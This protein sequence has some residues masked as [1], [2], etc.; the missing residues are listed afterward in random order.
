MEGFLWMTSHLCRAGVA[1]GRA[2]VGLPLRLCLSAA[3]H[4]AA[5]AR[6]RTDGKP[7]APGLDNL[8]N[9]EPE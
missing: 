7:C 1:T 5:L 9:R 4:E 6:S 8:Q 3:Q 2:T